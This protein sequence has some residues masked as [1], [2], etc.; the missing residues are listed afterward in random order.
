MSKVDT[1]RH[2]KK[3]R[4]TR[5]AKPSPPDYPTAVARV[6][7]TSDKVL[8]RWTLHPRDEAGQL[9]DVS[10]FTVEGIPHVV[11]LAT[12]HACTAQQLARTYLSRLGLATDEIDGYRTKLYAPNGWTPKQA[13]VV[14]AGERDLVVEI[15]NLEALEPKGTT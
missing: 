7:G 13:V 14:S 10:A 12:H 11:F 15:Y 1:Q 8:P 9:G 6:K 2:P 5:P 4:S 3:N